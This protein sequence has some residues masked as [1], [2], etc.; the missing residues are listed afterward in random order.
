MHFYSRAGEFCNDD[1]PAA[2]QVQPPVRPSISSQCGTRHGAAAGGG[3]GLGS[4][5]RN[6]QATGMWESREVSLRTKSPTNQLD[7]LEKM[8]RDIDYF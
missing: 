3:I 5:K 8:K 7:L 2:C 1:Q 6:D 4:C